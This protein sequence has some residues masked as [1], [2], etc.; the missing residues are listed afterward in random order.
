LPTLF[1]IWKQTVLQG[2]SRLHGSIAGRN[3]QEKNNFNN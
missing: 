1:C 3:D 2:R